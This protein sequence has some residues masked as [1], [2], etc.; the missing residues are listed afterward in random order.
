MLVAQ[1]RST[2]CHPMDYSLPCSSIH[3]IFQA[4]ILEWVAISF[5]RD[6]PNPGRHYPICMY[7]GMA[8]FPSG[9]M[10][11]NLLANV[12]DR[13]DS[14]SNSRSERSPTGGHG[15]LLEYSCLENPMDGGAWWATVRTVTRVKWDWRDLAHTQEWQKAT[16]LTGL[17]HQRKTQWPEE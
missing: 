3:G 2:L 5:S 13:R 6:L 8:G 10:V 16:A 1:S 17:K 15:N 7:L 12:G 4:K 11:K 9:L 14:R